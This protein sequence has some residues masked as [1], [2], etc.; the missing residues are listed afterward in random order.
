MAVSPLKTSLSI[1]DSI[2]AVETKTPFARWANR[3]LIFFLL[4]F[5]LSVPHSVAAAHI[6]LGVC[7]IAWI[8]RDLSM[9]RSH[10]SRT[11]IDL[12]LLCFA[13]LTILSSVFSV[14]PG[15]SLPKLKSLLLFGVVYI[16][17]A[18]LH[19][20]GVKLMASLIIASSLL[21]VGFS[22][23]EKVFGRGMVVTAIHSDS[24]F[25]GSQLQTG[26]VIWMIA[27]RR[28]YT[29]DEAAQVIRTRRTDSILDIEALHEGDPVP[30]TL[31]VTNELKT[32][33]NP[34]GI[35]AGGRSRQFRVS[36]FIRQFLTYAE[37]MQIM[38]MLAF[39]GLITSLRYRRRNLTPTIFGLLFVLFSLGLS[40]TATRAV[41]A[42]LIIALLFVSI[43]VGGRFAPVI[44]VVTALI[45]GGLGFYVLKT[46][47]QKTTVSFDDDSTARRI[48]YAGAGLRM[49]PHNPLLGVGMDSHK[50]HWKE[51]GFP[52]DYITHT[53]ST[54]IQIALER[55]LPALGC[56]LWLMAAMLIMTWRGYKQAEIRQDDFCESLML[57]AFG[58]LIGFSISSL[59]NYNF[60]DSEALLMLL[61]VVSLSIVMRDPGENTK[62]TK[63]TKDTK[64]AF[65]SFVIF[66]CFVFSP[67]PSQSK[68]QQEIIKLSTDLVVID[69]QVLN[70]KTGDMVSGLK[71]QDFE[72]YEDGAK[73][74]I[75]HFSQD[76]L[77]LSVILLID[78]S[79]SVSPALN[80]IRDGALMALNRLKE[81][82]E[83]A[84]IAFSTKTQLVQDFTVDRQAVV[85][86]IGHIEKASVIG[87][88]TLLF[89]ALRDAALHMSKAGNPASRRVIITITD[90]VSWDY[91]Y[92]GITEK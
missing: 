78:L 20:R 54:P 41:M 36:G 61:L 14:E 71:A 58:A 3:V 38:A 37:Q 34:L 67:Q 75:N 26:D 33:D 82:D 62:Q 15:I 35:E 8:A 27:R 40:L 83:V 87:Q 13:A 55:G 25:A 46:A 73:Q 88:G 66:V 79:A 65:V 52:G 16:V 63:I 69:A 86:N 21:G 12:P 49:I 31:I 89:P 92:Y 17:A 45:I 56:Y 77:S 81:S 51:W 84:V 76:K 28:I 4:L 80:E 60:G 22:L 9:R 10:F 7:L 42:S 48:A 19:K 59:A 39:G 23:A 30:L 18:N 53:H 90:N 91:Y 5:S 1:F 85:N 11:P 74:V 29:P 32:K 72:I 43:S 68:A 47:R 64:S 24:P 2:A 50:R 44:A 6:S 70:R 57:G